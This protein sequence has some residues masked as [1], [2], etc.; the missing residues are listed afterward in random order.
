L[1]NDERVVWEKAIKSM[2]EENLI[3][4]KQ[5]ANASSADG[6]LESLS[7]IVKNKKAIVDL[8]KDK[9][10]VVVNKKIRGESLALN[11]RDLPKF[12][13]SSSAVK[14]FPNEEVLERVDH[15]LRTFGSILN[16]SSLDLEIQWAKLLSLCM[17]NG[18]RA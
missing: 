12:Q 5:V 10:S 2:K 15:Y 13:L 16:S 14:A 17:P 18:E 3:F 4:M 11:R 9:E 6:R 8:M 1:E 7:K